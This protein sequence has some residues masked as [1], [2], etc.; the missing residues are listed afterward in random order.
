MKASATPLWLVELGDVGHL[1]FMDNPPLIEVSETITKVLRLFPLCTQHHCQQGLECTTCRMEAAFELLWNHFL[2]QN[3]V[4]GFGAARDEDV[5]RC[6]R[7]ALAAWVVATGY[8]PA[9]D[10]TRFSQ[11]KL[12]EL[13]GADSLREPFENGNQFEAL[14]MLASQEL[15][16]VKGKGLNVR[17]R[18]ER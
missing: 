5:R 15:T 11:C 3:A 6:S 1:Q 12:D 4:C 8:R 14:V 13:G 7:A 18:F 17:T 9:S 16:K 2:L 10:R